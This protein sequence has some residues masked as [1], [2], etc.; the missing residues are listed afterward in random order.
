MRE[1]FTSEEAFEE[2]YGYW[3]GHY[4]RVLALRQQIRNEEKKA[5]L[6]ENK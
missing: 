1:D 2:C 4:G 6:N 5:K 3:M